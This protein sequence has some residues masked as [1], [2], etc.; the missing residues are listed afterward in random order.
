MPGQEDYFRQLQLPFFKKERFDVKDMGWFTVLFFAVVIVGCSNAVNLTDGLDGLA[1]GCAVSA[2][3]AYGVF[4]YVTGN[5]VM[6]RYLLIEHNAA[7]GELVP[8]MLGL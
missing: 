6:S 3:L 1:C 5:Q 2:G 4:C 8:V 7:A